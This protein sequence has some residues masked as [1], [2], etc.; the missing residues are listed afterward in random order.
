MSESRLQQDVFNQLLSLVAK[1]GI[2]QEKLLYQAR[3]NG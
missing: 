2:T 1:A 3:I